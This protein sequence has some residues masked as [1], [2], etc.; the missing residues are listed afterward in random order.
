MDCHLLSRRTRLLADHAQQHRAAENHRHA[1]VL[2]RG[3]RLAQH[4][5]P[6]TVLPVSNILCAVLSD[7]NPPH[8]ACIARS[9]FIAASSAV[10]A[11]SGEK[12][13]SQDNGGMPEIAPDKNK[14]RV[15]NTGI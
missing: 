1:S 15:L 11:A 14:Q 2:G 7:R 9:D 10:T 3:H 6:D 5:G 4:S 8:R 13:S 12:D